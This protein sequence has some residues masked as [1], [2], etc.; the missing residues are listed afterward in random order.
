RY[1]AEEIRAASGVELGSNLYVLNKYDIVRAILGQLPYIEDIRINR[2]LP[3]TLLIEVHESGRPFALVQEGSAWLV[4]SGGK[5]VEQLPEKETGQYGRISGCELL[6]PSVGTNIALATEYAAQE[7]SLL[8]L[9]EAL[10]A[11]GLTENVDGIRM[12]DLSCINM[13]YIGRFTVRMDYGADY[14][15][16]LKKLTKTLESDK[17]QSNMTGTIDLRLDSERIYLIQNVR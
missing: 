4:S 9:L 7:T 12:D 14:D 10:D 3:D 5:I 6:A 1:T 8:A 16:E 15:F 13:D 17:I 11:A 2:K